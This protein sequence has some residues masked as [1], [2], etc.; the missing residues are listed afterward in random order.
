MEDNHLVLRPTEF[1]GAQ[2]YKTWRIYDL[3]LVEIA[4]G[5]LDEELAGGCPVCPYFAEIKLL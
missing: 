2:R 4:L 3:S 1:M 5:H